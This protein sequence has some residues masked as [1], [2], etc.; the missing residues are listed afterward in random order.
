[1]GKLHDRM[2]EDLVLKGYS[3][4]TQDGY[5][6]CARTFTRHFMRSPEDMGEQEI[7]EFLFHLAKRK[8]SPFTQDQ[9]VNAIKFLYSVTLKR[10]EVVKDI[11]HPKRPKV[12]PVILSQEEVLSFFEK[13]RSIKYKAIVATAYAAG[14]RISEV[15]AL[16]INDIDSKRMRI[17][18]RCGKGK[19]DRYVMLGE[20][21]LALL[22]EY[23][24]TARPKGDYLFPGQKPGTHLSTATVSLVVRRV[25]K[26]AGL[27]KKA[28][29]HTF[30]HCF[31]THL[32]EA[33]TDIRILQVLLGH[34]SIKTTLRYTH[35]T[36]RLIGKLA[37]PLDMIQPSS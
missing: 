30:R 35:I 22:R 27:S 31:A 3:H 19:K 32:M 5:L 15:C 18:I 14:L 1:M 21:L 36:D 28:T 23:F 29:M 17:H 9:Y 11:P 20:S 6:R 25:N 8:V 4:N 33:G 16:R 34:S 2:R 10:P 24:K 26:N 7:R 37:S 12:L 13:I